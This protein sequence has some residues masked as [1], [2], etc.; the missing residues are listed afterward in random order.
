MELKRYGDILNRR[1]WIIIVT[2]LF[3]LAVVAFGTFRATP[4]YSASTLVRVATYSADTYIN[5]NY[6]ERVMQTYVYVLTS[7]PFLEQVIHRLSLP[8]DPD[9]LARAITVEMLSG[10]ELIKISV[11]DPDPQRAAMITNMLGTLLLEEGQRLYVGAGKNARQILEEQLMTQ[12]AQL[13]E[14]RALLATL[15]AASDASQ[16]PDAAAQNLAAK[17]RVGEQTYA[18]LLNEYERARLQESVRANSLSVI[19][20]AVPPSSPSKP[21]VALSLALGALVG[22][23]GGIGLALVFE[24]LDPTIHSAE[25]LEEKMDVPLLGRVPI[26]VGKRSTAARGDALR[27]LSTNILSLAANNEI[28][29]LLVTSPEP[30][31]GKTTIAAYLAIAMAQAGRRIILVDGDLRNPTLH[32]LLGLQQEK[33]LSDV[34]GDA[35]QLDSALKETKI[36]GVTA[37]TAGGVNAHTTELLYA[38][39]MP[40]LIQRL[41]ERADLVL[42]DSPPVLVSADATVLAPNVDGVLLVTARNQTTERQLTLALKQLRQVGSTVIGLVYNKARLDNGGY[43]Y[44]RRYDR[45]ARKSN[46]LD[47]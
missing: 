14:D 26:F 43:G 27:V 47:S 17:I 41:T 1:K 12:E 31:A 10:T 40:S 30:E 16:T 45:G 5:L 38:P 25:D 24:L 42:W 44:Y 19:E 11:E 23:I 15:S 22:L 6:S 37:L 46:R 7:R 3:T 35:R 8:I 28:K 32:S 18:V 39:A 9:E 36:R 34:L 4:I 13:R 20:P 21:K 29:T 2:A 33:G